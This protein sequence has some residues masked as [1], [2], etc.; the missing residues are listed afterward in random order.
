MTAMPVLPYARCPTMAAHRSD[1]LFSLEA[2]VVLLALLALAS[3]TGCP[4][5]A[6]PDFGKLPTITS[7]DPQAEAELREARQLDEHG[8]DRAAAKSYARF[9][10]KR[11]KDP[12]VP[13]A[14]LALGRVLLREGNAAEAKDHFDRVAQ[15]S[16]PAI[17]EQGRFYGAV[18]RHRLGDDAS[19]VKTL[20]PMIGRPTDP[21]DT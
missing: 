4:G 15:H 1:P 17:A 14:E 20:Q 11:P 10:E 5:H 18:A 7:D 13:V 2:P 8:Q 16:D 9:V 21:E 3:A 6:G 12:L 19:A